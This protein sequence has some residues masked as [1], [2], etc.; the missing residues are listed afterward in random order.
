MSDQTPKTTRR[1]VQFTPE[2]RA[3]GLE[4]F[5]KREEAALAWEDWLL[6]MRQEYDIDPTTPRVSYNPITGRLVVLKETAGEHS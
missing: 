4:L 3:E 5:Q 2:Q 6:R 1:D